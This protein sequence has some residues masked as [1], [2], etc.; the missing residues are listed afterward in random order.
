MK[1]CRHRF[2]ID[3][4]DYFSP[5]DIKSLG[6][7]HAILVTHEHYDH[8]DASRTVKMQET[9]GAILVCNPGAYAPLKSRVAE[10]NLVLLEPDKAADV[11]R[12]R[13]TAIKSVHPG[14][15]PI[16]FIVEVD[17]LS[18]FHGSDSGYTDAIERY[19]SRAK[20][21]FVPVG[22][23]SP[24]ASVADAVEMVR[25]LRCTTAV[26]I[27]GSEDEASCFRERLQKESPDVRVIVPE[28]LKV[29]KV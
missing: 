15:K 16:M 8:F 20:V 28:P 24:T 1:A 26:P 11:K 13:I 29:Y 14:K 22:K 25:T 19:G 21:A 5:E 3:P 9:T 6:E 17:E 4:A 7:L 18:F 27:H 23:P 2:L 10:E 12:A